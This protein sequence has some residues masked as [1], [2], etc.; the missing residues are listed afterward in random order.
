MRVLR[1]GG[2]A[3]QQD[4]GREKQR[5]RCKTAG[6]KS[7]CIVGTE[8]LGFLQPFCHIKKKWRCARIRFLTS[9]HSTAKTTRGKAEIKM[10]LLFVFSSA[11]P[12]SFGSTVVEKKER[13]QLRVTVVEALDSRQQL[14]TLHH[15]FS[16]GRPLVTRR[17]VVVSPAR[18]EKNT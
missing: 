4:S 5:Q 10:V 14:F 16:L 1:G 6:N 2:P 3:L 11:W 8:L 13:A 7:G 17:G 18:K 9:N 12:S 15:T